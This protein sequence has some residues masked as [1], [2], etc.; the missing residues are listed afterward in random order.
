MPDSQQDSL[1]DPEEP[2]ES[3]KDFLTCLFSVLWGN[4]Q[5][6]LSSSPLSHKQLFYFYSLEGAVKAT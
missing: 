4:D 6:M 3:S 5:L 1:Q 2:S